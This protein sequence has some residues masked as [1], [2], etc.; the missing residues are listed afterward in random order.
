MITA[1]FSLFRSMKKELPLIFHF[2]T[3]PSKFGGDNRTRTCDPLRVEQVL[4]RLSYA[5]S[6][7]A[8]TNTNE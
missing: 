4:Y 8:R 1:V 7:F 2:A 6:T 5:S 3:T